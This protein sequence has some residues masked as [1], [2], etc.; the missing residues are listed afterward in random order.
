MAL[1]WLLALGAALRIALIGYSVWHD[2]RHALKYTDIDYAVF[3]DAARYLRRPSA[4]NTAQGPLGRLLRLG[5][6][7]SRETYRYTPLLA[8]LLLPNEFLHP[9][10]GKCLFAA[11]D[12]V[13]CILLARLLKLRRVASARRD[14]IVSLVWLLNPMTIGISTRGSSEATLGVLVLAC[15]YAAETDRW[16]WA[17]VLLGLSTHFKIYPFIYGVSCVMRLGSFEKWPANPSKAL[18]VGPVLRFFALAAST[19]IG[20]NLAMYL[21]YVFRAFHTSLTRPVSWGKPFLDEALLYH[22]YRLDA[23]HNF[24]PAFYP[25]QLSQTSQSVFASFLPQLFISLLLGVA[26]GRTDLG[27]AWFLQTTAFVTFNRVCTSQVS[28]SPVLPPTHSATVLP[29]VPP[30]PPLCHRPLPH[31]PRPSPRPPLCLGRRPSHL[32]APRVPARV[33]RPARRAPRLAR[34]AGVPGR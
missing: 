33:P 4:S 30:P 21:V 26:Y 24:A 25:I 5:D 14:V 9:L 3:S 17:A 16:D 22:F 12:L 13:I 32:A 15:L 6:P 7:Y 27:L 29:L 34:V 31:V 8:G 1:R 10:F 28:P 19:F 11:C 20:L 23:A 2:E 18:L